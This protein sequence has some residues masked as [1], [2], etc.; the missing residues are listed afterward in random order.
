MLLEFW[1][2][3]WCLW[4]SSHLQSFGLKFAIIFPKFM[5]KLLSLTHSIYHSLVQGC[6]WLVKEEF[7]SDPVSIKV[8]LPCY[9]PHMS[10][11]IPFAQGYDVLTCWFSS[12]NSFDFI[13]KIKFQ[14]LHLSLLGEIAKD[15]SAADQVP[16][17]LSMIYFNHIDQ[18]GCEMMFTQ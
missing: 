7:A 12:S 13:I 15:F 10:G 18:D 16:K 17:F 8:M 5:S 1:N 14:S 4:M 11:Y 3:T 6:L 2:V 9:L